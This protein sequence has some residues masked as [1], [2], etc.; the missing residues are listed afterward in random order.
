MEE[1]KK[2]LA[3]IKAELTKGSTRQLDTR[4]MDYYVANGYRASVG[5]Y[6]L[7]IKYKA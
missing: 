6:Y 5:G 7:E 3:R 2:E 4:N 1:A